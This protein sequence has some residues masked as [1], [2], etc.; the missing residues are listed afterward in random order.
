MLELVAKILQKYFT[1][2]SLFDLN[3][4][5]ASAIFTLGIIMWFLTEKFGISKIVPLAIFLTLIWFALSLIGKRIYEVDFHFTQFLIALFVPI[6]GSHL[7]KL[8]KLDDELTENLKLLSSFS[9]LFQSKTAEQRIESTLKLL[10]ALLPISEAIIFYLIDREL[11]PVGRTRKN[12]TSTEPLPTR[13]AAWRDIVNM[14][15]E[16]ISSGQTKLTKNENKTCIA[17]PLVS[18]EEYVGVFYVEVQAN[19]EEEEKK[20]IES[21]SEQLARNFQRRE[22]KKL[23]LP[24]QSWWGFLS[25]QLSRNRNEL[26]KIIRNNIKEQAF[27]ILATSFLKE[28][29]AVSYLDGTL[30]Y[31]N[32]QMRHLANLKSSDPSEIDLT[33]L[34]DRFKTRTFN[35]PQLALRKVLQTGESYEN[36][37]FFEETGKTLKI[38]ITLVEIASNE[39]IHET[40]ISTKPACFLVV[41]S[42]I[43]AV[44]ENEKLRSDMVNLMSH[45]IRTPLTSIQGFAELLMLDDTISQ[46][47]KEFISTIFKES[48]RLARMLNTFLSIAKLEQSDKQEFQKI[49][50]KLDSLVSEVVQ[51]MQDKAKRKRIRLIEKADPNIPPIAADKGLVAKAISH[52]IDNAI[53]YSPERTS[54]IITTAIEPDYLRVTVE[55]R[56][57][58]IPKEEQE[59]IWQKFYRI[60]REG[61]DKEEESTG[62]G[63]ALVKEIV[64]RHNGSVEVESEVGFGSKFS[65]RLPRL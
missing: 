63:L 17:A 6:I 54:V 34:L 4:W 23:T 31:A 30:A 3:W 53:K 58:G 26:L 25:T 40:G 35:E 29:F 32:R 45:E 46:E 15:E 18:E 38:Q 1:D 64:E 52:L 33:T 16:A 12:T 8:K 9:Y 51:T 21:V 61:Q 19:L 55:D 50:V 20:L 5:E 22:A 39:S 47:N 62:L 2:Y 7:M 36:E 14:C 49:P 65:I 27:S 24:N 59:K 13:Q 11:K 42:D 10:K 37:L 57:Y 56:G 43:T 41:I 44:K 60:V 28:A 48:Q